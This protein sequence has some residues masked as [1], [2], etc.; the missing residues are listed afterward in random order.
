MN[1]V[2]QIV[3]IGCGAV[4]GLA[5]ACLLLAPRLPETLGRGLPARVSRL[6]EPTRL[7][8]SL[9]LLVAGY[10]L[11]VWSMP[12][13]VSAVQLGRRWWYIWLVVAV[14]LIA[15]SLAQDRW[16]VRRSRGSNSGSDE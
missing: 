5:G 15:G 12:A 9:V 14:G 6:T 8:I 1:A 13:S 16:D 7:L 11:I 10:H 4:V 2:V 3:M